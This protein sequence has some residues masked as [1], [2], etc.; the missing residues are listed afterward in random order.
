MELSFGTPWLGLLAVP[1]LAALWRHKREQ[2]RRAPTLPFPDASLTRALE[3][4]AWVRFARV[5]P[6]ALLGLTLA[7]VVAGLARPQRVRFLAP[8]AAEGTDILLAID[9]S[10][11]ML[12][13]DFDPKDRMQ[14][15]KEA[16][17]EFIRRRPS[18]RIGIA[19][20]AGFALLQCPLTLDHAA[21]LDFLDLV[22]VGLIKADGT[23]I[24]DGLGTAVNH[25]REAPGKSKTIVLLTDGSNNSGEIDPMTAARAAASY[26]IKVYTIG[27]GSRGPTLIPIQDPTFGRKLVRIP[28][29]LDERTMQAIA[30]LTGGRYFRAENLAQLHEVYADIDRLEK[31]AAPSPERVQ[32]QDLAAWALLPAL[33]LLLLE[34]VLSRTVLIRLP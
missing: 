23:A 11:S 22:E 10:R 18:D 33:M 32:R 5:L 2:S 24:G 26:G 4:G 28:D 34:T 16:A 9:V 21:L 8:S 1:A 31:S 6:A 20:F 7:C 12:A 29:D 27:T 14:A 13:L 19:V 15:A 30:G 25:L 3:P 17:R